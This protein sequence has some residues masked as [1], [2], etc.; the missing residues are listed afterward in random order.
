[1]AAALFRRPHRARARLRGVVRGRAHRLP[2][3]ARQSDHVS[4]GMGSLR[5]DAGRDPLFRRLRFCERP[6]P[7][8][9]PR[10][11]AQG[12]DH[13]HPRAGAAMRSLAKSRAWDLVARWYSIPLLLVVWQAAVG[14]GLV[15]SR[16]LPGP[17]R[18]LAALVTDLGNGAL[19]YHAGVTLSR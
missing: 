4:R 15:E 1:R 13:R 2:R 10:A 6:H 3:G 14:S 5:R 7:A 18:V 11:R 9:D 12:T 8:R 19:G 17:E 16:L